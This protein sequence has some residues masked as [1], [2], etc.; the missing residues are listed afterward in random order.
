MKLRFLVVA[1]GVL[2]VFGWGLP[3]LCAQETGEVMV[4]GG[5]PEDVLEEFAG[6]QLPPLEVLA[7]AGR[8][9]ASGAARDTGF[10][11]RGRVMHWL[12]HFSSL[13]GALSDDLVGEAGLQPVCG[14]QHISME[15]DAPMLYWSYSDT[16]N[17]WTSNYNV[18]LD[19]ETCTKD[20]TNILRY[21][22]T[23]VWFDSAGP[24]RMLVGADGGIRVW[25]NG[26]EVIT[27]YG[28]AEYEE[29]QYEATVDLR[30]GWN[31]IVVKFYVPDLT[32]GQAQGI[33]SA[34]WS[35]R[36]VDGDGTAPI[37]AVQSVDGWCGPEDGPKGWVLFNSAAHLRGVGSTWRSD[38]RLTNPYGHPLR[39]TIIYRPEGQVTAGSQEAP[40]TVAS[41]RRG[42]GP[43]TR[44]FTL[45]AYQTEVYRDLLPALG[46]S[47]DQKGMLAVNGFDVVDAKDKDVVNLRT[48]NQTAEG[49]FGTTIPPLGIQDARPSGR[50]VF[51]GLRNGPG[52]RTNVA[53]TPA[54][55][56]ED[57]TEFSVTLW[58]HASGTVKTRSFTGTGYFQ[59]N[60]IF[61]KLGAG[62]LKTDS[63]VLFVDYQSSPNGGRRWF[64]ATVNDNHTSDPVFVSPGYGIPLPSGN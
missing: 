30:Q 52:F 21:F 33:Q 47:G 35:L 42:T 7:Q 39:V 62:N 10:D 40:A 5:L 24:A 34:K 58:D 44:T 19:L 49:T 17:M 12:S 53:C 32:P 63:A 8:L 38:L 3:V 55:A 59:V 43:I 13:H 25:F 15:P 4:P 50:Q 14:G 56:F 61:R 36:F 54:T 16:G 46:V 6:R 31:F 20:Y 57:P 11:P 26:T 37:A 28:P 23:Q 64:S 22:E 9:S 2:M 1:L 29:D 41:P 51:F 48:F 27:Q 18:P 45:S 60:D